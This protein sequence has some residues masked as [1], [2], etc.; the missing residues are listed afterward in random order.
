VKTEEVESRELAEGKMSIGGKIILSL[1]F[2]VAQG[3]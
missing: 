3:T 1:Y 2:Q